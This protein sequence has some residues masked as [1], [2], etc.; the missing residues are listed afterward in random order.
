MELFPSFTPFH[1]GLLKNSKSINHKGLNPEY[2]EYTKVTKD[3]NTK[4]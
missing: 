3:C 4:L 1:L 2:S